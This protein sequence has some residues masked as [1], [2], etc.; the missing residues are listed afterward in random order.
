MSS[1]IR[2]LFGGNAAD[3][4]LGRVQHINPAALCFQI[5]NMSKH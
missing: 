2:Y 4:A 5:Q 3:A 1:F